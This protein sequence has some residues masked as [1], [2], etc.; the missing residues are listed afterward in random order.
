MFEPLAIGNCTLNA[1][2][3]EDRTMNRSSGTS[4]EEVARGIRTAKVS[5]PSTMTERMYQRARG[6]SSRSKQLKYSLAAL[7][8]TLFEL[9]REVIGTARSLESRYTATRPRRMARRTTSVR[10]AAPIFPQIAAT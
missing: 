6:G 8:L 4:G 9:Y 1:E 3:S 2:K 7:S 10:F 5:A